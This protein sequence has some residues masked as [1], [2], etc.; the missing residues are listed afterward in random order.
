MSG[1]GCRCRCGCTRNSCRWG[2]GSRMSGCG[3]RRRHLHSG[4]DYDFIGDEIS[5]I[6]KLYPNS[7]LI[8]RAVGQIYIDQ[9]VQIFVVLGNV[10]N[11]EISFVLLLTISRLAER[12][13]RQLISY[14]ICR[15]FLAPLYRHI[16]EV[17]DANEFPLRIETLVSGSHSQVNTGRERVRLNYRR[18]FNYQ[19][20]PHYSPNCQC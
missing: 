2:Y 1:C 3:C 16:F 20:Q 8:F 6:A 10:I 12:Y 9:I 15:R 4:A 17:V 11:S 5:P 13:T 7:N 18:R 19:L 14:P